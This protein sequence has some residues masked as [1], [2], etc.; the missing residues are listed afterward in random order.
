MFMKD[1]EFDGL[2][3]TTLSPTQYGKWLSFAQELSGR[4]QLPSAG[5]IDRLVWEHTGER[6][7]ET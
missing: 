6:K 2:L 4:L 7:I 5:H 3:P 1:F